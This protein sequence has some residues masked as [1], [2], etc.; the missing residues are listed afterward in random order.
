MGPAVLRASE[1]CSPSAV[2]RFLVCV[3]ALKSK[4]Y[5]IYYITD[6]RYEQN[7]TVPTY[8]QSSFVIRG[9]PVID[10]SKCNIRTDYIKAH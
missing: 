10:F 7:V 3:Y 6:A 4:L 2:R 1:H 9:L 8:E 5:N